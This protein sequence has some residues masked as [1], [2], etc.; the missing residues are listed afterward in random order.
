MQN[1]AHNLPTVPVNLSETMLVCYKKECFNHEF[2][3]LLT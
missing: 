1:F 2:G 3:C